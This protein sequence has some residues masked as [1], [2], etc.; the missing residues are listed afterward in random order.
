MLVWR[1]NTWG[2]R[3]YLEDPAATI[4]M[5][6]QFGEPNWSRGHHRLMWTFDLLYSYIAVYQS[7]L[8]MLLRTT[9][10]FPTL[11]HLSAHLYL[12]SPL[13]YSTSAGPSRAHSEQPAARTSVRAAPHRSSPYLRTVRRRWGHR[14]CVC[15]AA[16]ARESRPSVWTLRRSCA[17][18]APG[19][20]VD[21][22]PGESRTRSLSVSVRQE[23]RERDC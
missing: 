11:S 1:E 19:L 12:Y 14:R 15:R 20:V 5:K 13:L 17:V 7:L 2:R 8:P 10:T 9:P 4:D 3:L 23:N 22:W 21:G 16:A 18:G 6:K